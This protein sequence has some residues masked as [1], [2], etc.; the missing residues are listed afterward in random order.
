MARR[1]RK[2]STGARYRS[3]DIVRH[4]RQR[5][6]LVPIEIEQRR[7]GALKDMDRHSTRW[8]RDSRLGS[9]LGQL[10]VAGL[11]TDEQ[12]E[13]GL[14]VAR[15]WTAWARLADCPSRHPQAIGLPVATSP[16]ADALPLSKDE[17]AALYEAGMETP[18]ERWDRLTKTMERLRAAVRDAPA[19]AL[20]WSLLETV[21]ADDLIPP[22]LV[23]GQWPTGW[24]ALRG[25]L[26]A[27]AKVFGIKGQRQAA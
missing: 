11:I 1:G 17:L 19:H 10:H 23:A 5:D 14:A 9:A 3:G 16:D 7:R 26:D 25:A 8:M 15:V 24:D 18:D 13:A 6:P 22:R 21:C 12:H 4:Q 2:R 27:A 20:A